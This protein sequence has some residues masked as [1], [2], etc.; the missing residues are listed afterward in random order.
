ME[1]KIQVLIVEDELIV[2][3]YMQDCLQR[4]DYEIA[5]IA[6]NYNDAVDMLKETLPDII[7]MD[8]SL[9]GFRNGIDLG[10]YVSANYGIPFIFTT[11][12]SD[13]MTI[14]RAK[15]VM[16]GAY[17]IKPFSEEDLYAAIETALT[18]YSGRQARAGGS[19]APQLPAA[20]NAIFVKHKDRFVKLSPDELCYIEADDNYCFLYTPSARYALKTSLKTLQENLPGYF[21]RIH[22][23]YVV[24]L[25]QLKS[26]KADEVQVGATTLPIGKSFFPAFIKKLNIIQ[27]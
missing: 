6:V 3:D 2:A 27:G 10:G 19:S 14:D 11:S 5:G 12:H 1:K 15:Q 22:R 18:Q 9:K 7:L 8:I 16:P 24:N 23:S 21:W 17:L 13:R 25:R 4:L 26:F 20:D